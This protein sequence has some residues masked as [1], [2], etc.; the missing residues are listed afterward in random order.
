MKTKLLLFAVLALSMQSSFGQTVP[1]PD[2]KWAFQTDVKD[3][4]G[5]LNG[6]ATPSG[7]SFI[8]DAT[9]GKVM[10]LDGLVGYVSLPLFC[11]GI[12]D[13]TVSCWWNWTGGAV[14]QRVYSFGYTNSW[15][16]QAGP[17]KVNTLYLVPSDGNGDLHLCEQTAGPWHDIATV[18][19]DSGKWYH[20]VFVQHGDTIRLYMNN[21]KYYEVD[22]VN[23]SITNLGNLY[24]DSMNVIGKSHWYG[25][26]LYKGMITDL[27]IFKTAL[28][29]AQVSTLYLA[30]LNTAVE[31]ASINS[32][33]NLYSVNGRIYINNL[34]QQ[35]SQGAIYDITGR[36]IYNFK[37]A[38][39]LSSIQLNSGIYIVRLKGA[40]LNYSSKVIIR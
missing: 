9:K 19:I 6:Q 13:V 4:S 23:E 32:N 10:Q 18:K 30:G 14:W 5:K 24:P 2:Y 26:P 8:T 16:L 29:S 33:I 34:R 17:T 37:S 39:G 1:T 38:T 11:Q 31:T 12:K 15:A 25:D 40:N 21:Q 27:E 20:S 22:T 35:I 28:D 3:A 7:V 36:N